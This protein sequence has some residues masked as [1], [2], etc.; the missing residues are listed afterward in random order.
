MVQS[1]RPND[2]GVVELGILTRNGETR[3]VAVEDVLAAKLF[4]L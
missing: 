2:E 3:R 1:V 4:P